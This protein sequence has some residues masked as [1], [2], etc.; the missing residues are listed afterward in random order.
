VALIERGLLPKLERIA[1]GRGS[2]Q[3]DDML[4]GKQLSTEI[5]FFQQL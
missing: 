1:R 5:M 3:R 2:N 4:K